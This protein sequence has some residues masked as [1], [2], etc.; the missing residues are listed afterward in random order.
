ML[1]SDLKRRTG[2]LRVS[3][4]SAFLSYMHQIGRHRADWLGV[5]VRLSLLRAYH[6]REHHIRAAA[7][8]FD[9]LARRFNGET[10]AL[11]T[12][13]IVFLCR[14][15]GPDDIEPVLT[16][17]RYLFE[18]DPLLYLEKE[19]GAELCAWYEL[20]VDYDALLKVAQNAAQQA[21]AIA[22][23]TGLS[24]RAPAF[25]PL[26]AGRLGRIAE[27]LSQAD[28][29]NIIR[30]QPVC[31]MPSAG[32][33]EPLFREI[34]VSIQDLRQVVAPK[35][36][37]LA[38]RWLFQHLT[39][40]LDRRVLVAV[41]QL[42]SGIAKGHFSLNLN[43][44][45]ILSQ[46]FLSFERALPMEARDTVVLELQPIDVLADME[47]FMFARDV[48]RERGYRLCLDGLNQRTL[49]LFDREGLGFDLIK[50]AWSPKLI[51]DPVGRVHSRIAQVVEATGPSSVI[52]CHCD[53]E[54]AI[55]FGRS[56]GISMFQGYHVDSA[57][58]GTQAHRGP[59]WS[60][61]AHS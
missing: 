32:V 22:G 42:G 7:S 55:A 58:H 45:T 29:A 60:I 8:C 50:L 48:I 17:V 31:R 25:E 54:E 38:N 37:L 30:R 2:A 6:R 24:H 39:E 14:G 49:G 51:D 18:D 15:A 46:D 1:T 9:G 56:V 3:A 61:I 16:K 34:F 57:L 47:L 36:D 53:S 19:G 43:V 5:Q 4:E 28:L 11:G 27:I 41:P 33:P 10:F 23:K 26:D 44:A 40:V 20:E 52:L 13:D 21:Q 12:G 35:I 59:A